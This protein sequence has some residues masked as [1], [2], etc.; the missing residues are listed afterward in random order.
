MR[1]RGRLS[2]AHSISGAATTSPSI[3]YLCFLKEKSP[4]GPRHPGEWRRCF[5]G[6]VIVAKHT[7]PAS[8]RLSPERFGVLSVP[9]LAGRDVL[10]AWRGPFVCLLLE[11]SPRIYRVREAGRADERETRSHDMEN[12]LPG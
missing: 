3:A 9:V 6:L 11:T 8:V 2:P 7:C 1:Q 5:L 10:C 12:V 4:R